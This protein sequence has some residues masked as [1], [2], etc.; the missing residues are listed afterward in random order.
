MAKIF[1]NTDKKALPQENNINPQ[2]WDQT[3]L[4]D[5]TRIARVTDTVGA[6]IAMA[7][8]GTSIPT[9]FARVLL[10]D[11][12]FAQVNALG[13]DS[14]SVYGKLV[15]ECLDFLE[16]IFNFTD[17][18][19]VKKWNVSDE[20]SNLKSSTSKK[21]NNLGNSLEKFAR[22]LNVQDIYLFYYEKFI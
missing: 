7:K 13:H 22:D 16:F 12:A 21:H 14:D 9:P 4:Y 18:I 1:N 10:F 17:K 19:T 6:G 3:P 2:G 20:I 8:M 5:D 11:T 15:S